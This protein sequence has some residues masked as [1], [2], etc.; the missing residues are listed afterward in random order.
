[1]GQKQPEFY[2]IHAA[3]AARAWIL[4]VILGA[5]FELDEST[6]LSYHNI[7]SY[8]L[9]CAAGTGLAGLSDALWNRRT[10]LRAN[11]FPHCDLETWIGRVPGVEEVEWGA[12]E[13]AWVSRNNALIRLAAAQ[14]G[15]S[16]QVAELVDRL[17]SSRV[18]VIMGTSTSSIGRT[19]QAYRHMQSEQTFTPEYLQPEIHNPHSPGAFASWLF[20]T[21]G[22]CMTI[23]TACSSSAKVFA[24]A[25][26]WLD[27]GLVDAVVVGGADTLCLSVLYGFHSLQLVS[28]DPCRPFDRARNGINIGEAAGF[29]ILEAADEP[30]GISMSGYG[31]SSDAHHMSHPHPEGA[32]ASAAMTAAL[33]RSGLDPDEIGYI[34]L[35]G[36]ASPAND[37]IESMAI[38]KIFDESH[39]RISSTKGWTGHAL[40]A[41]GIV[42]SVI[43]MESL[44]NRRFPGTLNLSDPD[45]DLDFSVA[46]DNGEF[47][48]SSAMTNSFGFGGNNCSLV[49]TR[50]P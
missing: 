27:L 8:T 34:N 15:F 28:A 33:E 22:P 14:D 36:T 26:R 5:S 44:R 23:S 45:P 37:V 31:E 1:M 13:S 43:V 38:G 49:F 29:A 20:G 6:P 7:A 4:G 32:G 25:S 50:H 19:E 42:E 18:G 21:T 12:D 35:H 48:Q 9:T 16:E 30:S 2:P 41:A 40:G 46:M 24:S 39:T 3:N 11:D 47:S 10:G 17:G